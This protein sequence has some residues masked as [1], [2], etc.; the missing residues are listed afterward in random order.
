VTQKVSV[1]AVIDN[2]NQVNSV[3]NQHGA[4][5]LP[6]DTAA[7]ILAVRSN[8]AIASALLVLADAVASTKRSSA[9]DGRD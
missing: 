5:P 2:I 3:I 4:T 7:R 1:D 9:D 8:L 6:A